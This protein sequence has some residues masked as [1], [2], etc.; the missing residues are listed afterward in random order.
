MD[1]A[2]TPHP[3]EAEQLELLF[4][5]RN[6][7]VLRALRRA[8]TASAVAQVLELPQNLVHYRINKL[9]EVGLLRVKEETGKGRV[10]ETVH[11]TFTVPPSLV[12][13]LKDAVPEMLTTLLNRVYR[14]FFNEF[15]KMSLALSTFDEEGDTVTVDLE[16]NIGVEGE[17]RQEDERFHFVPRTAATTVKLSKTSYEALNKK[18]GDAISEASD[19]E[20]GE[21]CTFAV[22][23]Y[24]GG[25]LR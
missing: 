23:G 5:L 16:R 17:R 1:N 15:E 24:R 6:V 20:G 2:K 11:E 7:K 22:L 21:L 10:F 25:S 12:D 4:D 13:E 9:L 8:D 3:L 14:E 18:L 19:K